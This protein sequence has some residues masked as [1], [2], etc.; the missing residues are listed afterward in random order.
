MRRVVLARRI[1][2]GALSLAALVGGWLWIGGRQS[3]AQPLKTIGVG[4]QP[5]GIALDQRAGRAAVINTGDSSVSIIDTHGGSIVTTVYPRHGLP[6]AVAMDS[7]ADHTFVA[8]AGTTSSARS[9][10]A[11]PVSVLET[12]RGRILRSVSIPGLVRGIVADERIGRVFVL[13]DMAYP[14][15]KRGG[16]TILDAASGTVLNTAPIGA[17]PVGI[18]VDTRSGRVLVV[19]QGGVFLAGVGTVSVLD[20]RSGAAL[21]TVPVGQRPM[22]VAV[23]EAT[24]HAFVTNNGGS[25]SMIDTRRARLVAT[26]NVDPQPDA[27]GV[28]ATT[29]H[30][31]VTTLGR[32]RVAMLDARTGAVLR[33]IPVGDRP[34]VVAVDARTHR[35]FIGNDVGGTTT[36][37]DSATGSALG[38]VAVG[39]DPMDAAVDEQTGHVFIVNMSAESTRPTFWSRLGCRVRALVNRRCSGMMYGA[40]SSRGSVSMLD[41]SR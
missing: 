13:T 33:A 19:N 22:A 18:A 39:Q 25:V 34:M 15:V 35:A 8:G 37:L 20:A 26:T 29:H 30:V 38:T 6:L 9:T 21:G 27:V 12:R 24:G 31:F 36:V 10:I 28:D 16:V 3:L 32:N 7:R 11:S 2:A 4:R 17:S 14:K 5:T 40:V 23:D 1:G 41:A